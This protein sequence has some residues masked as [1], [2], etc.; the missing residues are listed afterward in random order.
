M[1]RPHAEALGQALH[2]G[3][4]LIECSLLND[5][6]QRPLDGCPAADPGAGKGSGFGPAAQA[7]AEAG[8]LR[9]G[10]RR[11]ERNVCRPGGAHRTDRT[12]VDA[13]RVDASIEP[14]IIGRVSRQARLIAF[15]KVER[16]AHDNTRSRSPAKRLFGDDVRF[17][18]AQAA[19]LRYILMAL[20]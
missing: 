3:S 19:W 16:H 14:P 5:E 2:S 10:R 15:R 17:W 18:P 11:E 4:L 8:R 12:A 1:P 7:W 6:P 13:R 20:R 9:R